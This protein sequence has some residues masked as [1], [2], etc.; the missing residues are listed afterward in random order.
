M[1]ASPGYI[2]MRNIYVFTWI[3]IDA[4]YIYIYIYI[5][6]GDAREYAAAC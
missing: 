5:Y 1:H 6:S 4:I 3:Y 2:L